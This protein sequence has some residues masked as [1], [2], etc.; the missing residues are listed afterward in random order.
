MI[1]TMLTSPERI[2]H[3]V[4][5]LEV[6]FLANRDDNLRFGLL[7]DFRDATEEKPTGTKRS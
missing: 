6:R 5:A 1:P 3:L 2:G 4:D 7:T